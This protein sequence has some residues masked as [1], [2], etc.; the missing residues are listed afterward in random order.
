MV[1]IGIIMRIRPVASDSGGRSNWAMGQSAALA[2][3]WQCGVHSRLAPR[4]SGWPAAASVAVGR[5]SVRVSALRK[6]PSSPA[7]L[8]GVAVGREYRLLAPRNST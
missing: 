6:Y 1:I 2:R 4:A 5:A 8:F 7:L 3:H